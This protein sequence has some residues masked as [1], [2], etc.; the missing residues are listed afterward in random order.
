MADYKNIE[1]EQERKEQ[2]VKNAMGD[3]SA[4][5]GQH[6]YKV[7]NEKFNVVD[8]YRWTLS[9]KN[10]ETP[11]IQL[12]EYEVNEST[13]STQ[14]GFYQRAAANLLSDDPMSPYEG[15]FPRTPTN[16]VFKF[17]YF[18]DVNFE[19]NTPVWQSLDTLQ[20][21]ANVLKGITG[22]LGGEKAANFVGNLIQGAAT[23]GGGVA[24]AVYPKVGIMDRPRL[25]QNH[26]F[27]SIS[28][29]FPLF[30]TVDAADWDKNR[31]LCW[32]LVNNNLFI[33]RNFITSI[34]PVY[35]EVTIPGQHY[36]YAS[37]VTNLTVYNRGNMRMLTDR[38]GNKVLVPDAY[39]VNMTLTDMVMPS[40]NLFQHKS[41]IVIE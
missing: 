9:N 4:G 25:W 2:Q 28:I 24:A 27:R 14:I 29:K 40:R 39:E 5:A 20:E 33:K 34:P 26:D 11:F 32:V 6:L 3:P 15:L 41:Q 19:V 30:N 17:P 22:F 7:K 35:Y 21:G 37:C 38:N 10:K 18:S 1:E 23:V 36:S 16:N 31:Y 8:G 12:V 13:I